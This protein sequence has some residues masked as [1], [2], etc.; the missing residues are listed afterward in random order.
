[1]SW[2][3]ELARPDIVALKPYEHASWEPSLER[4]HA[5]EL[6]WRPADDDSRAGLNRYP[7]PQPRALDRAPRGPLRGGPG[8]VLVGTR[9]R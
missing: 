7:E 4:L 2:V 6:P 3:Q 5:N 9:K 8:L 1:M